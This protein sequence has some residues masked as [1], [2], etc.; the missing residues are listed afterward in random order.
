MINLL[1]RWVYG[2]RM[3]NNVRLATFWAITGL[4]FVVCLISGG[5]NHPLMDFQSKFA[6][7]QNSD[8]DQIYRNIDRGFGALT[9]AQLSKQQRS[10]VI[11]P[12][13]ANIKSVRWVLLGMVLAGGS[14]VLILG[15][16]RRNTRLI[17]V[18]SAIFS[19]AIIIIGIFWFSWV[20]KWLFVRGFFFW[21]V[22]SI[23]YIPIAFAD[24]LHD[25]I[26][27]VRQRRDVGASEES[28]ETRARRQQTTGAAA[29]ATT[30][31]GTNQPTAQQTTTPQGAPNVAVIPQPSVNPQ[32]A[33][34]GWRSLLDFV[35]V[36]LIMEW[37]LSLR[38]GRNR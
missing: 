26:D 14:I 25:L 34:R 35:T 36:D 13:F 7:S 37:L 17:V 15:I 9:D 19:L 6:L 18:A 4:L 8:I 5:F 3:N 23:I 33:G 29:G 11:Q 28:D 20:R 30:T 1:M 32:Q 27:R 10:Q 21:L 38:R 12:W 22:V 16:A 31:I 24:E 2:F